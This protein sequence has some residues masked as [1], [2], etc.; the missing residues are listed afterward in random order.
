MNSKHRCIYRKSMSESDIQHCITRTDSSE[1][2]NGV[3]V[4]T[5]TYNWTTPEEYANVKER[6]WVSI[7]RWQYTYVSWKELLERVGKTFVKYIKAI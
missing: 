7:E 2:V 4:K 5:T 1:L 3:Y 6:Y